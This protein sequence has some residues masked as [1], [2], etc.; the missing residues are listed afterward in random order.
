MMH[1]RIMNTGMTPIQEYRPSTKRL[2]VRVAG[3]FMIVAAIV[4]LGSGKA[5][6]GELILPLAVAGIAL[7]VTVFYWRSRASKP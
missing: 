3:F 7:L 2:V 4:I 5:V 1:N 6:S